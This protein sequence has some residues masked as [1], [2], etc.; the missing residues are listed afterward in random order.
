MNGGALERLV[1]EA[2]RRFV[3]NLALEQ[4]AWALTLAFAVLAA[5]LIAGSDVLGWF[6]PPV[7]FVAALAFG[8][9]RLRGRKP[10]DY[11]VAQRLD[12]ELGLHDSLS[13]AY[14]FRN[15]S[16]DVFSEEIKDAQREQAERQAA[17]VDVRAAVPLKLPANA[18]WCAVAA[19]AVAALFATRYGVQRSL[20]LRQ[21]LV[22]FDVDPFGSG[23]V[24]EAANRGPSPKS[25][26]ELMKQLSVQPPEVA[27][28]QGL[29]PAPDSALGVVDVPDVDNSNAETSSRAT[30]EKGPGAG[31]SS[32]QGE[33]NEGDGAG[34]PDPNR[35]ANDQG[36]VADSKNGHEAPNQQQPA[37]P[38]ETSSLMD[39]MRDAL[40]NM[41]AK[42]NTDKSQAG[43]QGR[44]AE[45]PRSGQQSGAARQQQAR[46]GMQSKGQQSDQPQTGDPQS[47]EDM[48]DADP[49]QSSQGKPGERNAQ[50][51]A[52]Q[53]NKS[54]M[55]K[56]D[57]DKDVELAEQLEAMGK[58]SEIIGKRNEKLQGEIMV[59]VN[60][61]KQGLRTQYSQRSAAHSD[62]GAEIRRDEIPLDYRSYVQEYFVEI[63]KE[64]SRTNGP[65]TAPRPL[66]AT[67]STSP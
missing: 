55:G 34:S 43:E 22:A 9:W 17:Q 24:R 25:T 12:H 37:Q 59:E 46:N 61:S 41:M 4:A 23:E 30:N 2:R 49:S 36:Q 57:G 63:R 15:T 5:L 32:E 38:G 21:P 60:S 51:A 31:E 26:E 39:K 20:D 16:V 8:V 58:I 40:A 10:S 1:S 18:R 6:W 19:C 3:L 27:S 13:T 54:G 56:Q 62:S 14:F 11:R 53:N 7:V 64:S 52:N 42:L 44:Q 47:N 48:Q 28:E 29:D 65:R 50:Q 33:S 67:P 45:R 66:S 35:A